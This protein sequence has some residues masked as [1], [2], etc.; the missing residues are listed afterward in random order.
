MEQ[1]GD[2]GILMDVVNP[3]K[4]QKDVTW[5]CLKSKYLTKNPQGV[6]EVFKCKALR[7]RAKEHTEVCD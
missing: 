2:R 5:G 3:E 6:L 4:K 7:L 1:Q